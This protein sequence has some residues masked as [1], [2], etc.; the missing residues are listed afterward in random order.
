LHEAAFGNPL[1][2][3][4]QALAN[5]FVGY[6][7]GIAI[8]IGVY[9]SNAF[10][11][12][13]FPFLS[14]MLF[15]HTSSDK[16]FVQYN[17]TAILDANFQVDEAKLAAQGVPWLT[18]TNAVGSVIQN[19]SIGAVFT[20]MVLWHRADI[21][22]SM[23]VLR[24]L[25]KIFKPREWSFPR[26]RRSG[27]ANHVPAEEAD[28]ICP[29]YG[30]MQSYDDVPTWWFGALWAA[31]AVLGLVMSRLAQST[32]EVWAYFVA[33]LVPVVTLPFTGIL[34]AMYG[35]PVNFQPLIHMIGAH[36][37]PGRPLA[38]LYFA[39]FGHDSLYQGKVM[40]RVGS[41]SIK[42]EGL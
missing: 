25:Q 34:Y 32:L 20:H 36:L 18:A 33:I 1:W 13:K 42:A 5:T 29:H 10:Q 14:T 31:S 28:A 40:L 11:A 38:N 15:S 26:L 17:Q 21:V 27:A 16:K 30:V 2:I 4:F 3:P 19:M 22:L 41:G 8:F 9:Y 23:H 6:I 37:L 24:P 39:G 7:L 35:V 12:K